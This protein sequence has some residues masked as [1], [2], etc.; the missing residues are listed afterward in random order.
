[1]L[2]NGIKI[3][4]HP[5]S[6]ESIKLLREHLVSLHDDGDDDSLFVRFG[7]LLR[8]IEELEI[9]CQTNWNC[10]LKATSKGEKD[11]NE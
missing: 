5:R 4:G 8:R 10:F 3:K 7:E 6:E 11:R 9:M 2:H 1:M